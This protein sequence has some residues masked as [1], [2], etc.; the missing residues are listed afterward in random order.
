MFNTKI[1]DK[2]KIWCHDYDATEWKQ[3]HPKNRCPYCGSERIYGQ[4]ILIC[5]DCSNSFG[6]VDLISE[7]KTP[8]LKDK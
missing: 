4:F 8:L 5:L 3:R 7:L 2:E 6:Y 1:V